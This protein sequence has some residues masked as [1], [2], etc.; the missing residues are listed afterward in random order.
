[1]KAERSIRSDAR[2]AQV[3]LE[4][5]GRAAGL[6]YVDLPEDIRHLVRQCLLDWLGVTLAG[7]T[8]GL[9]RIL[10][11]EADDGLLAASL[12]ARGFSSRA[13]SNPLKM[14]AL[15]LGLR[16]LIRSNAPSITST[17]EKSPRRMRMANSVALI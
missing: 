7:T 16:T 9:S 2:R 1:M 13:S 8:E 12:A 17:G 14:K 15:R 10:L 5:A 4:L 6:R 3:T 11:D